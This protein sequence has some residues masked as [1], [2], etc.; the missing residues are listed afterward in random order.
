MTENDRRDDY[1]EVLDGL[2][3]ASR[4]HAATKGETLDR[5]AGRARAIVAVS[6]L[7]VPRAT[8]AKLAGITRGRVQQILEDAGEA[9]ITGDAWA[10][11]DLRRLV[12]FA[13]ANRPVPSAGI[14]IRR[15]S[16]SGPHIGEGFGVAVRLTGDLEEDRD[17]IL[18]SIERLLVQVKAGEL[19]ELLRLT[20]EELDLVRGNLIDDEDQTP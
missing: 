1:R 6:G 9:G 18:A 20:E 4:Q 11:P 14:G 17:S 5:Q 10:D 3:Q 7:G 19:D 8:V 2:D 15:E 13:I 16:V 12:E